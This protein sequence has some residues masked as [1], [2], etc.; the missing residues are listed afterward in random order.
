MRRWRWPVLMVAAAVVTGVGVRAGAAGVMEYER[1]V[2]PVLERHCFSCHGPEKQKGGLRLDRKPNALRGGDSGEPAVVPGNSLRSHLGQLVTSNDPDQVMPPKGERLRPEEVALLQKWIDTGAHWTDRT[3]PVQVE[4]TA[5][6]PDVG[7]TEKDRQFW[8]FVPPRASEPAPARNGAWG[9]NKVDRFV[10]AKLEERGIGPAAEA[11]RE[12]LIRRLSFD[13]TG[14]P[15]TPEEVEAFVRDER[16]DAYEQLV[17]RLL[18]S[19]RS[20]RRFSA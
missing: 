13:L 2:R 15:P 5:V 11:G 18:A 4:T 9:R 8:S 10:L 1:D 7:I 20:G 6:G 14:L 12:T 16:P 19:P 3:A 17:D